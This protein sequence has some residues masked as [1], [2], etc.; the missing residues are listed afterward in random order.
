MGMNEM[1]KALKGLPAEVKRLLDE[2]GQLVGEIDSLNAELGQVKVSLEEKNI[3]IND[4]EDELA[5]ERVTTKS[6]QRN[7]QSQID[8]LEKE[9]QQMAEEMER[10][11]QK[12]AE[13]AERDPSAKESK[14]ARETIAKLQGDVDDL[15]QKC[16][17]TQ[18]DFDE[19]KASVDKDYIPV[20]TIEEGV[21]DYAEETDPKQ[22][23]DVFV[24]L[25]VLLAGSMPWGK[26]SKRLKAYFKKA[27]KEFNEAKRVQNV[28]NQ[29]GNGSSANVFN[30]KVE[31]KFENG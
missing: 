4:L 20:A 30:D 3:K 14:K 24:I 15:K 11:R 29:F 23:H 22:G 7:Y 1:L 6:M 17:N 26:C 19:L 31:G 2:N 25:N 21:R 18:Q 5:H 16:E 9:K 12:L 8:S 27:V 13:D 10:L 28:T